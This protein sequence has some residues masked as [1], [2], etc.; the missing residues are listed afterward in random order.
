MNCFLWKELLSDEEE[1]DHTAEAALQKYSSRR[2]MLSCADSKYSKSEKNLCTF[3]SKD[4]E[5]SA[6]NYFFKLPTTAAA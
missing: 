1:R 4:N 3:E 5:N 6:E 2:V